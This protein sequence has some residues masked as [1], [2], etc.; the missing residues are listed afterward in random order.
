MF[1][2]K[3]YR[4][5]TTRL[6]DYLPW[7]SLVAPGVVLQKD[8]CL[9]KTVSFRGPDLASSSNSELASTVARLN[10]ALK[11]LG[12]GWSMFVE[13]QRYV[14][15]DYPTS[16]W[17]H[18]AA[19]L[20]D[21]ERKEQF[22][23]EGQHFESAYYLTLVKQLPSAKSGKIVD[24]FYD[25]STAKDERVANRKELEQF[26]KGVQEIIDIMRGVFSFVEELDD[27]ETLTYLHSTI[28][29]NRHEVK[30]PEIPMYLDGLLPDQALTIGDI[31][32]LGENFIPTVTING[33]PVSSYPGILDD[34]NYLNIEYRWVVRYIFLDKEDARKE[35]DRYRKQWWSKRKN[36]WTLLKEEATKEESALVDNDASNKAADADAALQ[37]L[38]DDLVTYGYMTST[39]T[40]SHPDLDEAL[41]RMREV[42]KVIQSRGFVVMDETLNSFDAWLGSLPGHVYPNVR[43]PIMSTL[44]L[45]HTM[46]VSAVWAGGEKNKHLEGI[47]GVGTPHMQ[48]TTSGNTPFRLNLNVGD[49]GHTLI[50][51]PTG[52]GKSTL[53]AML[54]LQWLKYPDSQVVIFDKD[55]S[56]RTATMAVGGGYY[57]PGGENAPLAFQPLS[58]INEDSER[59]WAGTFIALLLR[60]Q[61]VVINPS[62]KREIDQA[63]ESLAAQDVSHRTLTV[64]ADTV[65]SKEVRDALR[66]YTIQGNYGQM[67][68]AEEDNFRVGSWQMIEMGS[69]MSMAQ[70]AVIPAL[71]YLFHRVDQ[72]FTGKPTLLVLDEAWLYLK[73]PVFM[74]Q[75]QAWLK[76]LRKKNVYVVFATQ[77]VADAS[78]S[79][80]MATIL[81]ACQTKI[82][83]PDEEALTP[84]M[85]AAYKK[86]GLSETEIRL[87]THAQKKR[88]Y[89]YRST[90]G[91]RM[92]TM[93]LGPVALAF[94]GMNNPEDHQ[95]LD[96]LS[97][98]PK[99]S[100]A[101]A[102]LEHRGLTWATE[103]LEVTRQSTTLNI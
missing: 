30:A 48:C 69:L 99:E 3:E 47:C 10:N 87:L 57:E 88:D 53:L 83:L 92:F 35:L 24:F 37:E 14:A 46:P 4:Q 74:E 50:I 44:N 63:L 67:Y 27:D 49:V 28:S 33:F 61:G 85:A 73:H 26:L 16:Q 60:E 7:A 81:S 70:E 40:V 34:L 56:A 13:A 51:G 12:S 84:G 94:A 100:H 17:Q 20:V 29:T 23:S 97:D 9:Q 6:P 72:M 102:I 32:M 15:P 2:L 71:Y 59:I 11:R 98:M 65:Q 41:R 18:S 43:R 78:E 75:L 8:S 22:Q 5:Q 36:I 66:T 21:Y 79:P 64:Y 68:D 42:K 89:Y 38:G 86:F 91:R 101:A 62:I 77:E 93:N 80:I 76:T 90:N 39:V 96:S 31:P 25:D 1:N 58:G 82:Y 55:R 54:E 52:A 45:A 103:I 95:F 19:W